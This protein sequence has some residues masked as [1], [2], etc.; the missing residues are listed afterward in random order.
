MHFW[1]SARSYT[2]IFSLGMQEIISKQLGV[3]KEKL[4]EFAVRHKNDIN[5]NPRFRNQFH[6]MCMQV[7]VDPLACR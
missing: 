6:Q 3:F 2:A 5:K 1:R 7:G 4:E